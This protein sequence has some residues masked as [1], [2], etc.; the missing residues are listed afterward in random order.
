LAAATALALARILSC[1]AFNRACSYSFYFLALIALL[2]FTSAIF[3]AFSAFSW[4]FFATFAAT[5]LAI[6]AF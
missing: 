4:A 6:F 3:F 1:L 2:A 5:S